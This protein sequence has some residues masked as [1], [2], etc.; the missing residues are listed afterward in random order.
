MEV[1]KAIIVSVGFLFI[2]GCVFYESEQTVKMKK[3]I[4]ELKEKAKWTR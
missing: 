4:S 3:E 2:L 1:I